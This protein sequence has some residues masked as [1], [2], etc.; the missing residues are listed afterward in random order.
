M[1]APVVC[2]VAVVLVSLVSKWI[3]FRFILINI[4]KKNLLKV[5]IINGSHLT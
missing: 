5:E 2:S 1:P 3:F 4:R